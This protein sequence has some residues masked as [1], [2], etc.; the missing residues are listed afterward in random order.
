[1]DFTPTIV[2]IHDGTLISIA[3]YETQ[4]IPDMSI[5]E[6]FDTWMYKEDYQNSAQK[7]IDIIHPHACDIF[8]WELKKIVD[9]IIEERKQELIKLGVKDERTMQ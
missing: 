1:M 9:A 8:M 2:K 6:A 3:M 4:G 5:R 7:L